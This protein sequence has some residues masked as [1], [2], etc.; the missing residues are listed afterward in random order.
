MIVFISIS[1]SVYSEEIAVLFN[2]NYFPFEFINDEG[3]PDGFTIDLI[4]A[5]A[6][7]GALT[8]RFIEKNWREADDLLF[9]GTIDL[10]PQY[11]TAKEH[12][13]IISSNNL[14]SVPFSLIFRED[15]KIKD[16]KD[17]A[18]GVLVLSSGD[19]SEMPILEEEFALRQIKTKSWTDALK[20]LSSGYGDYA[21][22]SSVHRYLS[23]EYNL[24]S[25]SQMKNLTFNIPYGF[26][27]AK[28]NKNLI[29]SVN[30]GISIVKASGEFN[31]I[32]K[33]WFGNEENLIIERSETRCRTT[34]YIGI[35]VFLIVVTLFYLN[36]R[37]VLK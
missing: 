12:E 29:N 9:L 18:E 21:V 13:S 15:K 5:V 23:R 4:Y 11:M 24:N 14:F 2:K 19:S 33:K 1:S 3:D 25:F 30:N 7:E 32:Y 35:A 17:L 22:I 10:A 26:Y 6:R 20:A 36:K 16:K 31:N 37:K 28:W 27:A 8:I 34:L